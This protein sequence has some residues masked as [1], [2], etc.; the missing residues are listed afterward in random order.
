MKPELDNFDIENKEVLVAYFPSIPW[1]ERI[2]EDGSRK[3]KPDP[4]VVENFKR[5]GFLTT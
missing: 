4:Y 1:K 2:A 5:G 3:K